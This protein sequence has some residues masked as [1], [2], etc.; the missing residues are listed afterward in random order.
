MFGFPASFARLAA[1]VLVLAACAPPR[2][3]AAPGPAAGWVGTWGTAPQLTEP[4]NM[5][6][7]PGLSGNTLRQVVR[8][9][10]GGERLRA[11]FSNEFG[12]APLTIEAAR[13]A[14]S[15]GEGAIDPA[16]DRALTFG[17]AA[18]VTIPPGGEAGSDPFAF[19]LPP[20]SPVAITLRFGQVPADLTGHPGSRTTSYLQPGEAAAGADLSGAV[21]SHH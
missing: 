10:V 6:P 13:V 11:R 19:P 5:P 9:S 2:P 15:G 1:A 7:A 20:L 17:G 14:A 18:A 12:T 16:T 21:P 4:A 8:V 3:A